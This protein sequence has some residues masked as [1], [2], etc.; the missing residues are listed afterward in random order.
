MSVA[1]LKDLCA[2]ISAPWSQLR[3]PRRC[4]G[5]APMVFTSPSRTVSAVWFLGRWTSMTYRVGAGD[6]VA[7]PMYGHGPVLNLGRTL[8]NHDHGVHEPWPA[9]GGCGG[10]YA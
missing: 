1:M 10:L 7:L 3:D 5:S 2:A 6:E 4:S 9:G 8:G